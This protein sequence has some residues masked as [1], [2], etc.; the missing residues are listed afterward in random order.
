MAC[1]SRTLNCDDNSLNGCEVDLTSTSTCGSTCANILTC[2][3][4]HGSAS[5]AAGACGISCSPSYDN[6]G[7]ANDGCE[8]SIATDPNN[9]NACGKT[10]SSNHIA[11]R[12]CSSG[13]CNGACTAGY[14]DCDTNK[15]SNGCETDL[16]SDAT[17]CGNCTTVCRYRSC[18]AGACSASTWGNNAVTAGPTTTKLSKNTLWT[19][20]IN[21]TPAG[22]AASTL[23][24]ALGMA[25]VVDGA[26]P[27]ANLRIGLYA[28]SG[29]SAPKTLE[30]QT[31]PLVTVN[32]VNEQLLTSAVAIPSGSHWIAFLADQD[33]RLHVDAATVSYAAASLTYA[34][35]STLPV[36]FPLPTGYTI[37]R[38]HMFAVT[39]P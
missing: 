33:I 8:T 14:G 20:K 12:T 13:V 32:G 2:S 23:L 16:Q 35:V 11:T 26:N 24:Q 4:E 27:V 28:D 22:G 36:T 6:C 39:T 1:P 29:A 37:E 9:C 5:C 34:S 30:A 18:L 38:G 15:Q 17:H 25:L 21:I 31:S 19:F 7:G 10:C 3:T